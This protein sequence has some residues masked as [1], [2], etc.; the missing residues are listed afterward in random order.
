MTYEIL[1]EVTCEI[2]LLKIKF[3]SNKYDSCR[4]NFE[5]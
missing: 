1:R 3:S 5:L 4:R 2:M